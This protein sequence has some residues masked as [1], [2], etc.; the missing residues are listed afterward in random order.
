MIFCFGR[1]VSFLGL[2]RSALR[3]NCR[4]CIGPVLVV[5]HEYGIPASGNILNI[6]DFRFLFDF[7]VSITISHFLV[8]HQVPGPS[9]RSLR[10]LLI[11]C[12][13]PLFEGRNGYVCFKRS[14][15]L[16]NIIKQLH[17]YNLQTQKQQPYLT[18]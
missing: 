16:N 2:G 5:I 12:S 9:S 8:G 11:L 13:S 3:R 10:E 6:F 17:S 15:I 18:R 1:L 4:S 7:V 14:T